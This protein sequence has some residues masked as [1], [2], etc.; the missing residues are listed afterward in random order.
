[1]PRAQA[2]PGSRGTHCRP[3][4]LTILRQLRARLLSQWAAVAA[5]LRQTTQRER[6]LLAA[7]GVGVL[8]YAPVLAWDARDRAEVA[9]AEALATREAAERDRQR[10]LSARSSSARDL[11]LEDMSRW[12][13][14]GANAETLRVRLEQDVQKAA[15]DAGMTGVTLVPNDATNQTGPVTW[16]PIEVQGDLTWTP[17]LN[18][19][20]E[21][22]G[23][24]EGFRVT[25]FAFERPPPPAFEGAPPSTA[26]RIRLELEFP[27]RGLLTEDDTP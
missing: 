5:R 27:T 15:A 19:L 14:E 11:A 18:F 12:G 21:I 26:G 7:L 20:D 6:L 2:S 24:P 10:A 23:W 25:R 13:F 16:I 17:T 22:A 3:L 1:M 4:A 9:Y 8:V